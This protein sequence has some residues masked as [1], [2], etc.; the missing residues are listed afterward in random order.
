[1]PSVCEKRP[2][3]R[4]DLSLPDWSHLE[5]VGSHFSLFPWDVC[6]LFNSGKDER[7]SALCSVCVYG[8]FS[9]QSAV[10]ERS[11]DVFLIN[12]SSNE[13]H[14]QCTYYDD[15]LLVRLSQ[16]FSSAKI[17]PSLCNII[18]EEIISTSKGLR[19][20]RKVINLVVVW[21]SRSW[22]GLPV[23]TLK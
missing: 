19:C 14:S 18:N 3:C 8:S 13:K 22:S 11:E 6:W 2:Q 9:S 1:M 5:H 7:L 23:N 21:C 4:A 17:W 15:M 10:L 16:K 20:F 12:K